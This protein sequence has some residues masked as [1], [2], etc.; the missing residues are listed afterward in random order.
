MPIYRER[1][2]ARRAL[3]STY[4]LEWRR[5]DLGVT[6]CGA[7]D[8]ERGYRWYQTPAQFL[9]GELV[10]GNSGRRFYAHYGGGADMVFLMRELAKL[11]SDFRIRGAFSNS[12][13]IM[14]RVERG[15]HSWLFVDS[16]W[17]MR[18]KL[19]KIGEWLGLP[20]LDDKSTDDMTPA[21]LRTYNERD[22]VILY[23]ALQ[24]FQEAILA[25]GG[26]LGITIASTALKTFLRK[27][28]KHPIRNG[29]A[30]DEY[31]ADA[32]TAS[33]VERFAE[34][35][36]RANYFDINSSFAYSM[37]SAVP[38]NMIGFETGRRGLVLPESGLWFADVTLRVRSEYP[39]IPFRS[40]SGRIFYP[41]GTF[42]TKI[43]SEDFA[44]GDFDIDSVHSIMR[45]EERDDMRG[46]AEDFYRLRLQSG[47]EGQVYKS[48]L[49]NLY[50]K[51]AEHDEKHV[52]EI[53]PT[54]NDWTGETM[55]LTPGVVVRCEKRPVK[56]SHVPISAMITARSRRY[57]LEHI[58]AA[59]KQGRVYYCD[60][61]SVI[62]DAELETCSH[63]KGDHS[64][65]AIDSCKQLGGLKKE[66]AV[67]RGRFVSPKLYAIEKEDG[68]Q[69]VKAKGFSRA[70]GILGPGELSG[71]P[72]GREA[73]E[74]A[75]REIVK[76]DSKKRADEGERVP[77]DYEVFA[78]LSEGHA[79]VIERMLRIRELIKSDG[80]DYTP[81]TVF[82]TK[83]IN[84]Q[85]RPK[86]RPYGGGSVP[87]DVEEIEDE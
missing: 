2:K 29:R 38:G 69:E 82:M 22:C 13:A 75:L 87:W 54:E 45:F 37:L 34:R 25:V 43:S 49:T 63:V 12:A 21:E 76:R 15:E 65:C 60:T 41:N 79:A 10:P 74:R 35:C 4:D 3:I 50:G 26:E 42:R 61:D 67:K 73:K 81:R 86:R 77:L 55:M 46:Y 71:L 16:F 68:G 11:P 23:Q 62:C 18:A 84:T 28:M 33:R 72:E 52:I 53:N 7:Y 14:V 20:K 80:I 78:R 66:F 40:A 27:Y 32:Y 85:L 58:R 44:C 9:R 31:V 59:A 56:H 8:E 51:F 19:A 5:E 1:R 39:P 48:A 17:T 30:L 24:R 47:F 64:A 36:E 83:T 57:L 70:L 6:L